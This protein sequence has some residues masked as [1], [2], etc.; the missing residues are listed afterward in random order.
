VA[1]L[2]GVL[3]RGRSVKAGGSSA[4]KVLTIADAQAILIVNTRKP[5]PEMRT[6]S[7]LEIADAIERLRDP[8]GDLKPVARI[9][10]VSVE[11]LQRFLSVRDLSGPVQ[12]LVASRRIDSLNVVHY[13]HKMSAADQARVARAAL[14]GRLSGSDVRALAPMHHRNPKVG[15]KALIQRHVASKDRKVYVIRLAS[16]SSPA[17]VSNA[18]KFLSSA[19]GQGGYLKSE[20]T[21][22]GIRLVFSERGIANLRQAAA[23]R[24]ATLRDYVT[25]LLAAQSDTTTA[26]P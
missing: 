14:K 21:C 24:H 23:L 10:G 16:S 26:T 1:C 19:A 18:R 11:M 12:K 17:E 4:R 6:S 5:R 3:A 8:S 15:A 25:Q 9:A 20:R 22:E 2:K 7:L 13:M